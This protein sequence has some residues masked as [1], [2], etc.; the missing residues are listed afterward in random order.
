MAD[1]PPMRQLAVPSVGWSAV[2]G[3]PAKAIAADAFVGERAR[4]LLCDR[5]LGAV[6]GGVE[7]GDL[8]QFWKFLRK[9]AYRRQ[10][11]GWCSGAS[12]ARRS[13]SSSSVG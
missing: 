12:G 2:V 1:D 13:S 8:G 9:D 4:Q 6:E 5:G 10:I 7:A 11:C 3:Q